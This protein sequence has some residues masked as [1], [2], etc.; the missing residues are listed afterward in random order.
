[1]AGDE[2]FDTVSVGRN[3]SGASKQAAS[4]ADFVTTATITGSDGAYS[5]RMMSIA[6]GPA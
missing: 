1:V 2:D 5:W 6:L 4:T 3:T